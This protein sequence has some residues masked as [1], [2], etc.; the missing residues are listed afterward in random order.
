[1]P[2]LCVA[3]C[4]FSQVSVDSMLTQVVFLIWFCLAQLKHL[5]TA[6]G[7]NQQNIKQ[8]LLFLN[9]EEHLCDTL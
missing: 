1:M 5:A 7:V 4:D 8:S 9:T 3:S 6:T 2:S